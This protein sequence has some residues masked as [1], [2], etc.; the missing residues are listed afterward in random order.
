MAER[1]TSQSTSGD[2]EQHVSPTPRPVGSTLP[3]PLVQPSETDSS[4]LSRTQDEVAENLAPPPGAFSA[5]PSDIANPMVHHPNIQIADSNTPPVAHNAGVSQE[6]SHDDQPPV[7]ERTASMSPISP[8]SPTVNDG[9]ETEGTEYCDEGV[10]LDGANEGV[11]I[12]L[13]LQ[14]VADDEAQRRNEGP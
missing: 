2:E 4:G 6:P 10:G 9:N 14:Q 3:V 11:D 13:L 1:L 5:S 8:S 12:D 7:R